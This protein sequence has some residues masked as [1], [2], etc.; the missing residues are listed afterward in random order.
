MLAT[1]DVL[2]SKQIARTRWK[3]K[4]KTVQ[5]KLIIHLL[6]SSQHAVLKDIVAM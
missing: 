2:A 1:L 6:L 4:Q 5:L 3:K